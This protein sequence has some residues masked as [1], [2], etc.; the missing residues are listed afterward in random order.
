[1]PNQYTCT[2][3]VQEKKLANQETQK[4]KQIEKVKKILSSAAP[5]I[6]TKHPVAVKRD[7]TSTQCSSVTSDSPVDPASN[8]SRSQVVASGRTHTPAIPGRKRA[9]S[10]VAVSSVHKRPCVAG[11]KARQNRGRRLTSTQD[12]Q[13]AVEIGANCSISRVNLE[14]LLV[15]AGVQVS[16]EDVLTRH[17]NLLCS[18]K[19]WFDCSL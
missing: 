17:T 14:H 11:T 4:Q 13:S 15:V 8:E 3:Q 9:C 10:E 6:S 1:M 2:F 12:N 7:I 19:S 16:V 5:S 18:S